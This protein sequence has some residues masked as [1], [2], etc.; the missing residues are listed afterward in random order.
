MTCYL[1]QNKHQHGLQKLVT[2]YLTSINNGLHNHTSLLYV[3]HTVFLSFAFLVHIVLCF[4][5]QMQQFIICAA[6][7]CFMYISDLCRYSVYCCLYL[8]CIVVEHCVFPVYCVL[9][10]VCRLVS[11]FIFALILM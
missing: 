7:T 3:T 5:S 4:V 6:P 9:S 10:V 11:C 2:P 1:L 8:I